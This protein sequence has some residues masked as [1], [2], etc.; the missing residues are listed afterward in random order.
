MP[1]VKQ[2]C[3]TILSLFCTTTIFAQQ[4]DTSFVKP[5][6]VFN[7]RNKFDIPAT[8][9]LAGWPLFAMSIIYDRDPVPVTEVNTLDIHNIN[10]FDR[11]IADNYD[12]KARKASDKFFYGS[13]PLPLFLLLDKKI[14]KDGLKV[15][16]LYLETMGVTG[17][18]YVTSAMLA[19]RFRPYAYNANVDITKRTRGGARNS[20]F[21]GHPA[22]VASSTFFMAEVYTSYHP[23]MREKWILYSVA[24]AAAVTT[25]LLRL[26]AGQHFRTDV[27][28]GLTVGTLSG[29]LIPHF[30][31]NKNY[32]KRRLTLMPNYENGATGFT[33]LYKIDKRR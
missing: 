10:K 30:H 26:K 27:L 24:G 28:T 32:D 33:A 29:I 1:N 21:A 7:I 3:V 16:L 4:K 14:R 13:M 11:P 12:E 15:G 9:V 17:S 22:F 2:Y 8:A 5:E 25:G 19:N 6:P 18:V 31:K 23:E 20:F